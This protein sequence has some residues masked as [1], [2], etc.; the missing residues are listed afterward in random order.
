M[1]DIAPTRILAELAV[2]PVGTTID[3]AFVADG[4]RIL[5]PDPS[6]L[7]MEVANTTPGSLNVFVLRGD[8]PPS[9]GAVT[10][11]FAVPATS[12]RILGPVDSGAVMLD[13]GNIEVAFEEG[14]EGVIEIY[15]IARNA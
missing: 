14:F 5:D 13:T 9:L 7:F 2:E 11:T 1:P 8:R 6:R 15:E 12:S 10:K 4:L 3:A